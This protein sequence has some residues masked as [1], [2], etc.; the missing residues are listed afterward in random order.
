MCNDEKL[1]KHQL[2]NKR[3]AKYEMS[4]FC[5]QYDLPPIAPSRQKGKKHDKIHKNYYHKKYRTNIV[6]PNDFYAKKKHVSKK[7]DKKKSGKGNALI[8]E[9]LVTTVKIANKNLVS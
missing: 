4:N 8:V 1:L 3:K 7:Y 2:K 5:E 9:N 6:K